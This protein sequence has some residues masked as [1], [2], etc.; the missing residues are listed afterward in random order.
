MKNLGGTNE[1]GYRF[2][3]YIIVCLFLFSNYSGR[4]SRSC[5]G[6]AGDFYSRLGDLADLADTIPCYL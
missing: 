5:M 2:C 1:K 3:P 6:I 4:D